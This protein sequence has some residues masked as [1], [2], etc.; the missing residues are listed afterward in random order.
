[1]EAER[2]LANLESLNRNLPEGV[3][4]THNYDPK[5][6]TL[7]I[8]PSGD[9]HIDELQL[10]RWLDVDIKYCFYNSP[11]CDLLTTKKQTGT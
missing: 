2:I 5:E 4:I 1:M 7:E 9:Y 8:R 6:G 3:T 10:V 11:G